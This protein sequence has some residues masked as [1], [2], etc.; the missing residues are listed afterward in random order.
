MNTHRWW[1]YPEEGKGQVP[2]CQWWREAAHQ[3][4]SPRPELPN[5]A[6]QGSWEGSPRPY[7]GSKKGG[8]LGV[9]TYP[10]TWRKPRESGKVGTYLKYASAE[11]LGQK[12]LHRQK[13]HKLEVR[14]DRPS[15]SARQHNRELPCHTDEQGQ[16]K[17][18][19]SLRHHRK[20]IAEHVELGNTRG[21]GEAG[22][23]LQEKKVVE[24]KGREV[25]RQGWGRRRGHDVG[26]H[27]SCCCHSR[28]HHLKRRQT[29][30]SEQGRAGCRF[31]PR[32]LP[33]EPSSTGAGAAE[34]GSATTQKPS[35]GCSLSPLAGPALPWQAAG[36][37]GLKP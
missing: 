25:G 29:K 13:R 23:L 20:R 31:R 7:P 27:S 21:A 11:S 16:E 33:I 19:G 3:R 22:Y 6:P 5:V 18:W 26:A 17:G 4:C 32:Q 9:P 1:Q 12:V 37:N 10:P 8:F 24:S 2:I 14:D 15:C 28:S 35:Q 34:E 30:S 36:K